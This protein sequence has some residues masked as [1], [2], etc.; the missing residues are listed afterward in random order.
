VGLRRELGKGWFG[1]AA[2]YA[3]FR[4]PTLNELHRPFR[5][6][7]DITEANARLKPER[8]QGVEA[9]LGL[10]QGDTRLGATLFANRLEDPVANVTLGAGPATFPIAGFVPA[11]GVLRRRQNVGAIDAVG[12]ELDAQHRLGQDLTLRGALSATRA[13]VD[14]EDAAPQLTGKR[15]AQAPRLTA[16][17]SADWRVSPSLFLAADLRHESARFD[18]DLNSRVLKS[19]TTLDVQARYAVTD[20]LAI[21]LS[22]RNAFDADVATGRTGDGI[23]SYDAPRT[24]RIGIAYAQ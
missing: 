9:G 8:L 1:R 14:G 15:P 23:V 5:V 4:P 13:R 21:R 12:L 17:A 16:T 20:A 24:L 19:A 11:G 3:G 10:D 18:D 6:G 22:L 2:G 7:N